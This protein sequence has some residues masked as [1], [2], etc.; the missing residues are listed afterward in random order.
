MMTQNM[1]WAIGLLLLAIFFALLEFLIPSAGLLGIGAAMAAVAALF[2]AYSES[3]A[4]G[5]T[6]TGFVAI[7]TPA[8]FFAAV[9][10]WPRTP[11]GRRILN[12]PPIDPDSD[13]DRSQESWAP[14]NPYQDL[15]SRVGIAKTNLLPSGSIEI[16]GRRYDAVA[17]GAAIDSG[18]RVEVFRVDGGRIRVRPTQRHVEQSPAAETSEDFDGVAGKTLDELDLEDLGDPLS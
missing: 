10:I 5:L 11:I 7:A 16:D 14:A 9:R 4:A 13:E 15:L 3:F 12:L 6:M 18:A 8:L 17:I 2:L 1:Y